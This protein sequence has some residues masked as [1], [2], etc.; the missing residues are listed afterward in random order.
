MTNNQMPDESRLRKPV[1]R[2]LLQ[3]RWRWSRSLTLGAQVCVIDGGGGVLLIRH[4][5]QRGW[6]FPGGGVEFGETIQDAARRELDE[7]AGIEP[8]AELA[9]HGIF[10]NQAAFP[11][12]HIALFILRQFEQV[13]VP[14][15]SF[16]I[17]E[18]GFFAPSALPAATTSG[19]R[20]RLGEILYGQ[21][22]A[23]QW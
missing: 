14:K 17:A 7:E 3:K 15:P 13:H 20:R 11:G 2:W 1:V 5:Y 16:E 18:Q 23:Q 10:D 22:I 6:H 8:R 19:T 12:D 9:L 4:G 21:P